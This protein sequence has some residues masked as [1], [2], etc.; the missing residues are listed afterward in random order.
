MRRITLSQYD[1]KVRELIE[2]I[3][4]DVTPFASR[5]LGRIQE[6]ERSFL[7]FCRTY[8]PHYF[9]VD[10]GRFHEIV[11]N[12]LDEVEKVVVIAAPRGFGKTTFITIARTIYSVVYR[13][14]RFVLIV[15]DTEEQA[16]DF[17]NSIRLEFEY[18]ERI[19]CDFGDI[20]DNLKFTK[21]EIRNRNF[22]ILA[23]GR[24][25]KVRGR[26]FG[27]YR[28][29]MVVIDD[30]ENDKNVKNKKLVD[31]GISWILSALLPGIA[32][33]NWSFYFVGNVLA[34]KCV[35]KE[36]VKKLD[37]RK[38]DFVYKEIKAIEQGESTWEAMFPMKTLEKLKKIMGSVLFNR[39]FQ[40]E[41][42]DEDS[43]FREEWIRY[44]DEVKT[45]DLKIVGYLD[46][47]VG[48]GEG[49][50]YKA[51]VTVGFNGSEYIVLDSWIRKASIKEMLRYVY[52]AYERYHH[53]VIGV[54]AN[55]F[56]MI[57]I[58]MLDE[59]AKEY[60]FILPVKAILVR[61]NKEARITRLSPLLERGKLIFTKNGDYEVLEEQIL[62]FGEGG[63]D[64][65][66]DALEGAVSLIE[67]Y[68]EKK[69][70]IKVKVIRDV[71]N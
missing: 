36:L 62:Y 42:S 21:N 69:K 49:S 60:G 1:A 67:R 44:V 28:P 56:Q 70:K 34:K 58:D 12:L 31:E 6:C 55:A 54:E 4:S 29:D 63:N 64:D 40:H 51:F 14:R 38:A 19:K 52:S 32:S 17:L 61:E 22:R 27:K 24:G 16:C 9:D 57:L 2:K 15:S 71:Q 45:D 37:E 18:N 8:L 10:F 43:I 7:L 41:V 46:P 11:S 53:S 13:K 35:L 59:L 48:A 3:L 30:F 33:K 26:R 5:D 66:P 65:G 20:I 68:F 50:D 25:Q 47:S 23:L 39:E